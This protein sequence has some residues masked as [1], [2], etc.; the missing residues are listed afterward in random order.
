VL[1]DP[2]PP[3]D[4]ATGIAR[5][6]SLVTVRNNQETAFRAKRTSAPDVFAAGDATT[7]PFK[8]IVIAMG[9]GAKATLSAFDRLIR[10]S[11]PLIEAA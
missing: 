1:T 7:S 9:D 4:Y 11:A 10:A 3:V 5:L 8:Q 2:A 6:A